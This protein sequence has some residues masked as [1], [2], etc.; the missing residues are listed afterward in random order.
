MLTNYNFLLF[1][2]VLVYKLSVNVKQAIYSLFNTYIASV[3]GGKFQ[4]YE[5][6]M[7][8]MPWLCHIA[9]K[10]IF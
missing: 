3:L 4:G 9:T 6:R 1:T 10:K 2:I 8:G 7:L 5:E